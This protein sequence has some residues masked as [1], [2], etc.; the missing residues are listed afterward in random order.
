M[1][2]LIVIII[3]TI[4]E[5]FHGVFAFVC[6]NNRKLNIKSPKQKMK[7]IIGTEYLM[8]RLGLKQLIIGNIVNIKKTIKN[9][10]PDIFK[11]VRITF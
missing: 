8:Y 1:I 7:E 9:P 10:R 3:M 4:K 11:I 6:L 5:P 2:R